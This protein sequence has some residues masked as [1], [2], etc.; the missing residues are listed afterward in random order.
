MAW[1][2]FAMQTDSTQVQIRR[3]TPADAEAIAWVVRQAW[4][5][6]VAPDSSGHQETAERVQ[7][8]LER[9]YA[10]VALDRGEVVGTVRLVR[11]PTPG[12]VGSGRS[13]NWGC[14]PSTASRGWPTG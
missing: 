3:A 1:V 13:G 5:D 7:A 11:H 10:W 6:R 12:S 2:G 9:G 8:D 14:C 4:A